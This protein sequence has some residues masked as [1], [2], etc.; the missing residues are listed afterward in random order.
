MFDS[1]DDH[2]SQRRRVFRAGLRVFQR[3]AWRAE[4][5]GV[6]HVPAHGPLLLLF[7]H[8][9]IFDGPLV[10]ANV[11]HEIELVGPG[12]FPMQPVERLIIAAYGLT[13]ANRGRTDRAGLKR[14]LD[15]LKAGR[16]LAMAP[17]GGTW[18][19]SIDVVKGGAA[20]LSQMTGAPMVPVALGGFYGAEEA[21][22]RLKRPRITIRFGEVLPPVPASPDRR[23]READLDAASRAIMRRLYDLLPAADRARYDH[24]GRATYDLRIDARTAD[25][26]SL[27]Y[28]GPPLPDLSA[29][30]EFMAKP[31]L[32]RPMPQ[33]AGLRVEPFLEARFF[34]PMEVRL[35]ARDLYRT[36]TRGA[37]DA[38][39]Q[40]RLGE[41]R[42]ALALAGLAAVRDEV[43][44]WAMTQGVRLRLRPIVKDPLELP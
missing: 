36:L 30:G 27:A 22:P 13:L 15:H 32:F 4:V 24:W 20:Y 6:E 35:A 43:C 40:Y 37:F 25:D 7:N 18:E 11:P 16:I 21:V 8:L 17:D 29:L 3:V 5:S 44:E 23:Q 14:M 10:V 2:Q 19:K 12:D 42:A 41:A 9:S 39:L 1:L 33:N 26:S 38:Y 28:G 34:A 31:N